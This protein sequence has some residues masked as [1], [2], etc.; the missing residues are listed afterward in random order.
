VTSVRAYNNKSNIFFTK[1][2]LYRG[3]ILSLYIFTLLMDEITKDIQ[4][5]ILL[6]HVVFDDMVL[7]DEGRIRVNQKLNCEHELYN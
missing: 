5:D 2:N 1:I 7:I 4:G 6:V 3:S